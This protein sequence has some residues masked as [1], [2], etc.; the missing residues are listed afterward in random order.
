MAFY[1]LEAVNEGVHGYRDNNIDIIR[2]DDK[3]SAF[4]QAGS[5]CKLIR[6][7]VGEWKIQL[8]LLVAELRPNLCRVSAPPQSALYLLPVSIYTSSGQC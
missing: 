1:R 3:K 5:L 7:V 8:G 4:G 2:Q 6:R